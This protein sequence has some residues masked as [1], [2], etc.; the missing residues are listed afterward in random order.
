MVDQ[1]LGHA[2]DDVGSFVRAYGPDEAHRIRFA[3]NGKHASAFIDANQDF[4]F[5]VVEYVCANA[6]EASPHLLADLFTES[7]NWAREAWGSPRGFEELGAALLTR[8]GEDVLPQF[9]S[10]FLQSF[11]TFA[12]CHQMKL[13]P[14][15]TRR[16]LQVTEERAAAATADDKSLWEGGRELF[17]KLAA[18][19]ASQG[20]AVLPPG[21][22]VTNVEIVPRWKLRGAAL[23]IKLRSVLGLDR[24]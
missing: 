4:R 15:L 16:L 23:W 5:L 18:G 10:G 11:D 21:T 6:G 7:A 22:S 24:D 9:L 8:G 17:A 3:W 14:V 2:L 20:W 12:E 19:T 1:R 13:D